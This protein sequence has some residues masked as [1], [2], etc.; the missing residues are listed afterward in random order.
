M[1]YPGISDPH[2][3]RLGG[4]GPRP[5]GPNPIMIHHSR[6][7]GSGDA[8][9]VETSFLILTGETTIKSKTSK[10][11]FRSQVERALQV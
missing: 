3:A 7:R 8:Q 1:F 9:I 11:E 6:D 2:P 4:S 5:R 10:I